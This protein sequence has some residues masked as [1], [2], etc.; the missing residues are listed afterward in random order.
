MNNRWGITGTQGDS[1]GKFRKQWTDTEFLKEYEK[2]V[3]DLERYLS[4]ANPDYIIALS[5][6]GPRLLEF[7]NE[8]KNIDFDCPVITERSLNFT[9]NN[10]FTNKNI[11]VFDDLIISGTTMW[12]LLD[13]LWNSY[14]LNS[15]EAVTTGLDTQTVARNA[16]DPDTGTIRIT[17]GNQIKTIPWT[18]FEPLNTNRRFNFVD[19]LSNS[20]YTLNKPYDLDFPLFSMIIDDRQMENLLAANNAY[21]VT[22]EAQSDG[23]LARY[24]VLPK[25]VNVQQF[26]AD[27]FSIDLK[28]SGLNKVRIYRN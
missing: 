6:T 11:L 2:S 20:I 9:D 8:R 3:N 13:E 28:N 19:Q 26:Y 18:W 15:L 25:D 14:D 16:F 23:Y 12:S 7:L 4:S 24:T 10:K 22:L 21:D 17:D 1:K 27:V 5:R